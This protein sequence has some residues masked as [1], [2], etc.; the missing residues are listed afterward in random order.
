MNNNSLQKISTQLKVD[1]LTSTTL[2][3]SGHPTSCLSCAE[4]ITTL[5]FHQMNKKD[6]FILSKGHAAPILYSALYHKKL[7]KENPNTLRKFTSPLEGHPMPNSLPQI[8]FATGSL[9]QGLSIAAGVALTKKIR[10]SKDKTY[11]LLGDS[12]LFEGSNYEAIQFITH[13]NLNNLTIIIDINRLGQRGETTLGHNIKKYKKRF[14]GFGL[15]TITI[16]GHSIPKIKKALKRKTKK[17]KIILAKTFKGNRISFLQNKENWHGK[18][19]TPEQL[20][21]ALKELPTQQATSDIRLATTATRPSNFHNLN[22]NNRN[23]TK[24]LQI[25][26]QATSTREAYGNYLKKLTRKNKSTIILDAEVS[27]STYAN[28]ANKKQFI[29]CFIGEQNMIGVALGLDK[30]GIQTY[31]ST[32]SAFLTRAH[33]QLR[34][35]AYSNPNNMTICGSHSGVSIGQDGAS[36]M[37][38]EDISMMRS[39]YNSKVFY[40][41]DAISTKNILKTIHKEK[42]LK[43]IRT[44]RA[45]LPIIYKE[46][47]KF[48]IGE[49]KII[50]QSKKDK[51]VLIGAGITLHECLKAHKEIKEKTAV[52]DI[53]SIKPF[54]HKKLFQFVEKHSKKIIIVED[55]YKAGGIGEMILAHPEAKNTKFKH[56]YVNKLPHSGTPEEL[57][58]YENI[59][60]T[61]IIKEVE[62][63]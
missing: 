17:P 50:K 6:E 22:R 7:I 8:K 21:L 36:Q 11:V 57:L 41:S 29:E 60:S 48:P 56:L 42:G 55:H 24:Q 20:T 10:K 49:F 13:Y 15:E 18:P 16:N 3:K 4:I 40:P 31:S 39:L 47:D 23:S 58:K 9:G 26:D 25:F 51:V 37:G 35:T 34:M 52:I 12:E 46:K 33:D 32:F 43:Y 30:L 2:A 59:D 19:L 53:Y 63:L 44:T 28:Q 1:S 62:K 54:N 38:L 14:Q 61:S 45:K 27:N 5:F